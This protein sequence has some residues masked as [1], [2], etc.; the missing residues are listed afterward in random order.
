MGEEETRACGF[1][2][3][4]VGKIQKGKTS[5]EDTK[6]AAEDM[7]RLGV[8]LLLFTGGDGTARDVY[9]VIGDRL[10]VL[11]IPSGVKIHFSRLRS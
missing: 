5:G 8:D 2:P 9:S 3:M 11:G 6:K 10:P 1:D 4:V 7:L